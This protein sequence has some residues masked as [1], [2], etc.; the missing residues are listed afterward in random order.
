MISDSNIENRK[1]W[2]RKRG[3]SEQLIKDQVTRAFYSTS[4]SS[5]NKSKQEKDTGISLVT[6]YHLRPNKDFNSLIKRNL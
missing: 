2:L 1:E 6:T 4:N 5:A 3:Y